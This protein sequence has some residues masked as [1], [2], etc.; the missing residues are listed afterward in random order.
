MRFLRILRGG[1]VGGKVDN[2]GA[3][4]EGGASRAAIGRVLDGARIGGILSPFCTPSRS[5]FDGR[6]RLYKG[7]LDRRVS[8]GA[9][10]IRTGVLH[11]LGWG[12]G[13]RFLSSLHAKNFRLFHHL[14]CDLL[15]SKLQQLPLHQDMVTFK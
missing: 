6:L 4:L 12:A 14:L 2:A 1:V 9:L 7:A 3:G 15:D 11:H 13:R 10:V 8:V 5:H